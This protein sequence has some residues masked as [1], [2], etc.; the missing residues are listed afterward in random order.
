MKGITQAAA[1]PLGRSALSNA[2]III[3]SYACSGAG[4]LSKAMSASSAL[5]CAQGTGVVP[6]CHSALATWQRVED[7]PG[8][9]SALAI[10]SV[11]A[12]I[13]AMLAITYSSAGTTRWCE[14]SYAPAARRISVARATAWSSMWRL[15]SLSV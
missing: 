8:G 4:L 9:S 10:K 13:G 3:L 14:T 12:L 11:R 1:P 6:L 15:F 7:R 5:S 2:P